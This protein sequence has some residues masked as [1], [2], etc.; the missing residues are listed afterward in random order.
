MC[1]KWYFKRNAS[2]SYSKKCFEKGIEI[3]LK[4]EFV[5]QPAIDNEDTDE[6]I[7]LKTCMDFKH[8]F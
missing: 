3:L 5:M 1:Y 7:K 4:I 8:S 6:L 2:V